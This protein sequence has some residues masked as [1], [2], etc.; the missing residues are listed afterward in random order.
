M[1]QKDISE[2]HLEDYNDIFAD[3]VNVLLFHG[4]RRVREEDLE[5]T[6][7]RSQYKAD[8]GNVHE[9]ERDVSKFWKAE[10]VKIA[11][12]GM[13]NQTLVDDDMPLRVI[14]YDGSSYRSQL[15]KRA[16][17]ANRKERY[18]VITMVLFFGKGHWTGSKSLFDQVKIPE[19][20]KPYVSDYK[21]NVFEISWL[22]DEQVA[23]FQSDFRIVADYFVQL[24]KNNNYVASKETICHVDEVLKTMAVLTGDNRFLETQPE[25]GKGGVTTMC[26]VLDRAEKRGIEIGIEKGIEEGRIKTIATFLSNG[27]TEEAAQQMLNATLEELTSAKELLQMA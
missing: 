12:Y 14:G 16:D 1:G 4:E 18:P 15:L 17:D 8:Q 22:S 23:M 24:R 3:I 21:V 19:E 2:K 7:Q 27:G 10:N 9:M 25:T 11:L 6:G 13:E 20:L 26:E 5:S